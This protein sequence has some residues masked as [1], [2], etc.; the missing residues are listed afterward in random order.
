[1]DK[2]IIDFKKESLREAEDYYKQLH[3]TPKQRR[4]IRLVSKLATNYIPI[5][6]YAMCGFA[7][8]AI[9]DYQV[10][11][12][13]EMSEYED[14]SAEAKLKMFSDLLK[15]IKEMLLGAIV[16]PEQ[17]SVLDTAVK[18]TYEFYKNNLL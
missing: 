8:M 13:I 10:D 7:Y 16:K 3:I 15:R 18:N 5:S 1:M 2:K 12:K 11:N 4:K 6:E 14:L 9:R 17:A